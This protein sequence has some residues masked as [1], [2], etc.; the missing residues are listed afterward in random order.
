VFYKRWQ[1]KDETGKR[2]PLDEPERYVTGK[3]VVLAANGIENPML[4][5]R[6]NAGNSS[7]TVGRYLMDHPIKQSYALANEPVYPF[8]GPQ[9]TSQFDG[10]RDGAFRK[11]FAG[12]KTSIKNDGWST[13]ITGAPRGGGVAPQKGDSDWHPGTLLDFV[14][15]WRYSGEKLRKS[16]ADH[17]VRQI[18]LNSACE[19][20]PEKGN[21]VSLSGKPDDIGVERPAIQYSV[22]DSQGY[23]RK[24]FD[25]IVEFHA[26]VFAAMGIPESRRKMQ[27][28]DPGAPL[29]FGGSGHIMGTTR[30]G[31]NATDSV[32]D[33]NC[34]AHNHQNLF[35]LGSSVFPTSSTANPTSTIAA[36]SL[37][38]AEAIKAQLRSQ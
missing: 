9:T 11:T 4:L 24:S 19:Q 33:K 7:K 18:T 10:F 2:V 27:H 22:D 3:V 29:D 37:R 35:V 20:L 1:W 30:M 32:V 38:A 26:R 16:L 6:S 31:N 8:R 23:V 15:N 25:K 14:Q 36:L 5:L 13:N 12:F 34:R 17:A 21:S 28:D